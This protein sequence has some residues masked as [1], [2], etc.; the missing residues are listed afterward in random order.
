MVIFKLTGKGIYIFN[1]A[2]FLLVFVSF[3]TVGSF[4]KNRRF[5]KLPNLFLFFVLSFEV[6]SEATVTFSFRF[7]FILFEK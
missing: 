6:L 7:V 4:D 3:Q 5:F 2:W 1:V